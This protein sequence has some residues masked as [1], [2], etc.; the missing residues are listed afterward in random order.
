MRAR[1]RRLRSLLRGIVTSPLDTP[2]RS[3]QQRT[4]VTQRTDE[5]NPGVYPPLPLTGLRLGRSLKRW[6]ADRR[7]PDNVASESRRQG[8]SGRQPL[9]DIGAMSAGTDHRAET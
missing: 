5:T 3:P 7:R 2:R 8:I 1:T 6:G 9:A 4:M